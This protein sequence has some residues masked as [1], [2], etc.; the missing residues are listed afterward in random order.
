M[1]GLGDLR[2]PAGSASGVGDGIGVRDDVNF[3]MSGERA[4][5]KLAGGIFSAGD[6]MGVRDSRA[7]FR[8]RLLTASRL[9]AVRGCSRL[10]P[11]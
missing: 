3:D 11:P 6:G 7:V 8:Q 5:R 1:L 9:E 2:K 10:T 4:P